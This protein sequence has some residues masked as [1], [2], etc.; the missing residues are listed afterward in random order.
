M[1][2]Q[3][4]K[5]APRDSYNAGPAIPG[6]VSHVGGEKLHVLMFVNKINVWSEGK[7]Y[8]ELCADSETPSQYPSKDDAKVD[9]REITTLEKQNAGDSAKQTKGMS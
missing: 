5:S 9:E 3:K 6:Y 1:V 4:Q 2:A 7:T 8:L